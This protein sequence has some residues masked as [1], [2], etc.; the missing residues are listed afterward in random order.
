MTFLLDTHIFLWWILEDPK[1]PRM[2]GDVLADPENALYF[3]AA[4]TWEMVIK[5]AIGK[6]SLPASPETF[7]REQLLLNDIT[8]LP[9]TMEHTFAL[10]GLPMIHKD[11]SPLNNSFSVC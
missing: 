6:L 4:S 2:T 10:A 11:P 7:L 5:S 3:S 9:I 8:P 1:L